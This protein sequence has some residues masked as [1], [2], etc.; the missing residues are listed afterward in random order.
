MLY[1]ISCSRLP[2]I[3]LNNLHQSTFITVYTYEFEC[4]VNVN[5]IIEFRQVAPR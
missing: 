1:V 2:E 4:H 3:A 5:V